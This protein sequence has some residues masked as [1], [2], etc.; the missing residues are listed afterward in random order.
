M[1]E[2][3]FYGFDLR[4]RH[5]YIW[6]GAVAVWLFAEIYLDLHK[7]QIGGVKKGDMI[8]FL[9]F[10]TSVFLVL[11]Y[12]PM[13]KSLFILTSMLFSVIIAQISKVVFR[14]EPKTAA[15]PH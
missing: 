14:S 11:W 4:K 8:F 9:I 2:T 1:I 5:D 10:P 12:L 13:V 7:K 6:A 15:A 3:D